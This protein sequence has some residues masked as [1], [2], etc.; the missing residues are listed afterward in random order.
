MTA[1]WFLAEHLPHFCLPCGDEGKPA[2]RSQIRRW[3]EAGA[4]IFNGTRPGPDDV[5]EFPIEELVFF[6]KGKRK[7]TIR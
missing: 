5:I 2:S 3:L 6:P 1:F 7:T 4:V